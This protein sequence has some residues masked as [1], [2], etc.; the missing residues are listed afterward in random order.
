MFLLFVY[1]YDVL[2]K[3]SDY[4]LRFL[5]KKVYMELLFFVFEKYSVYVEEI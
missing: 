2:V 4:L 3:V 5:G 1:Y